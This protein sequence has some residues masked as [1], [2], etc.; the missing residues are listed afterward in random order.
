MGN[1]LIQR[2]EVIF[3][4]EETSLPVV[5]VGTRP[6]QRNNSCIQGQVMGQSIFDWDASVA[7]IPY[8]S[9]R[10][11]LGFLHTLGADY[12]CVP[13][14]RMEEA[15]GYSENMPEWPAQGSVQ[16]Q[17]GMVIVKLSDYE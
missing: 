7:P 10:R 16:I 15:L 1:D 5:I 8:W 6:F 11:A 14:N 17:D 12:D 4:R 2:L 13:K 9:T 3:D